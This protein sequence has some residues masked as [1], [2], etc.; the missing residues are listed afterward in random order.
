MPGDPGGHPASAPTPPPPRSR[1]PASAP[2]TSTSRSC[3]TPRAGPRSCTWPSAASASTASR[4]SWS[5]A[6]ETEIGGRL[7]VNTDGGCIA[8]GEPI[9]ASGLRQVH[10]IVTQLRGEAGGPP[11]G[12]GPDR[13]HPRLRRARHQRLHGAGGP[14]DDHDPA[15]PTSTQCRPGARGMAAVGAREPR[16]GAGVGQPGADSVA[17]FENWTPSRSRSSRDRPHPR[18]TSGRSTTPAGGRSPGRAE[19][20]GAGLPTSYALR[21]SAGKRRVRRAAPAPRCSRSP[22][23]SSRRPSRSWGTG[24]SSASADVRGDAA[25]DLIACQLFSE[26]EAG[27]DLAA[28]RCAP[29]A[30]TATG[31]STATRSGPRGP[32]R[33]RSASRSPAPTRPRPGTRGS[34]SSWCRM[35][36]PGVDGAADPADDRRAAS[37]RSTSTTSRSRT[38]RRLGEVGQGWKV[39][40]TVLGFE[41]AA[42]GAGAQQPGGSF[43]QAA[44]TARQLGRLGDPADRGSC[45]PTSM[46]APRSSAGMR[47]R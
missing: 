22:R 32:G 21:R 18:L 3:R 41:R 14:S 16:D 28:V 17:V 5:P 7:P 35:D 9:G 8:N 46:C 20:G 10:E 26:T 12:R 33:R 11:G 13:L 4:R 31:C 27:S 37:T 39:A 38:R 2:P 24:A 19:Y 15:R 1:R 25:P 44:A 40:L 42:S 43:A 30:G 29:S 45:W 23:N 36:A 47:R 6:G 34:P